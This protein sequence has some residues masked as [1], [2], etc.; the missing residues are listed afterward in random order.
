MFHCTRAT[1]LKNKNKVTVTSNGSASLKAMRLTIIL[2]GPMS[3]MEKLLITWI[4][5]Q[6]TEACPSLYHSNH[7]QSKVFVILKKRL[8]QIVILVLLLSLDGSNNS[9]VIYHIM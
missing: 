8:N 1:V 2:K 7:G 9:N 3:D 4:E 5:D 6:N